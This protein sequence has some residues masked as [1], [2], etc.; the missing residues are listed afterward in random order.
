M[1]D[2]GV[3]EAAMAKGPIEASIG[4]KAEESTSPGN[5]NAPAR[6]DE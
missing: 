2:R 1:T 3:G 5:D 4:P 6:V